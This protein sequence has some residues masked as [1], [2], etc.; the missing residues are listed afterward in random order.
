MHYLFKY[1]LLESYQN[2]DQCCHCV[3]EFITKK[4]YNLD[5]IFDFTNLNN[6]HSIL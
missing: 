1:G 6:N 2:H 3:V 4:N 5:T